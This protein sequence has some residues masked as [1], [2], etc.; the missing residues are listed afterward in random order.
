MVGDDPA[1][2]IFMARRGG[3]MSVAVRTGVWGQ[4]DVTQLPAAHRPDHV[5][6]GVAELLG[7]LDRRVGL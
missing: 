4:G 1:L 7:Q 3:A 2:E 5:V 6:Q